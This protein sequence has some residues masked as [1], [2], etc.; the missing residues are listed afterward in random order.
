MNSDSFA[1][2]A[3]WPSPP[4]PDVRDVAELRLRAAGQMLTRV[5]DFDRKEERDFTRG[6]AVSLAFWFADNFWRLRYE[7]LPNGSA[8]SINWR[9]RHEMTSA[10]GGTLWPPIMIHSTGDRVLLAPVFARPVDIGSI[11]YVL[12]DIVTIAGS[13]FETGLETFFSQVIEYCAQAT[14]G[15]ALR[16]LVETIRTESAD[17]EWLSWRRIEARLGYDPDTVPNELMRQLGR[18]EDEVGAAAVDEAAA[19]APGRNASRYLAGAVEAA[20]GSE[21]VVDFEIAREAAVDLRSLSGALPWQLGREAARRIRDVAGVD[22][23]PI[24]TQA[25]S[26]LIKIPREG[27][28]RR[29]TAR[30][31]PYSARLREGGE[32]HRIA[33]QS[34]DPRDRRF[35]LSCA[36][37]DEIWVQADFGIISKAKTDRQKFQRAFAQNLLVPFGGMEGRVD[38]SDPTETDIQSAA[39]YYHV[40][41]NV[42]RRLL[43]LEGVIPNE[44]FEERLEAA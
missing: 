30:G 26:E 9:L 28:Q 15:P 1:L 43:I 27:L 31:L 44:T 37:A 7:S 35:E 13:T 6:S 32:R 4:L 19:A 22:N 8:P 10:A 29:S 3:R 38:L 40:H 21:V 11:R 39:K 41:P 34:A 25:F 17:P 14:D 16:E 5:S 33:L 18:L 20:K 12:P 2:T 42:I 24:R 36:L 23:Q